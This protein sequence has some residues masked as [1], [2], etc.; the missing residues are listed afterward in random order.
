LC[1]IIARGGDGK[2]EYN[3][4]SEL[5]IDPFKLDEE[6][7]IQPALYGKY[8]RLAAEAEEKRD[9]LKERVD[10][11]KT[12]LKK[13]QAEMDQKIRKNPKICGVPD[14][15]EAGIANGILLQPE[16]KA[17]LEALHQANLDLIKAEY[18][19]NILQGAVKAFDHRKSSLEYAVR[20]WER[21]YY[22][23]PCLPRS[24]SEGKRFAEIERGDVAAKL[25]KEMNK[26]K[27]KSAPEGETA[28]A[29]RR[30]RPD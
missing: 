4:E 5:A 1:I 9:Q 14:P 13:V 25:R 26:E 29:P 19:W 11:L 3:Y 17:A 15:K 23:V 2:V 6:C 8:S 20:L 12:D 22:A 30:R 21:G 27:E 24:P 16:Y 7:L 28:P 10:V 18:E